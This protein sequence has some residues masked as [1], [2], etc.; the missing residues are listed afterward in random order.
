[1]LGGWM[2]GRREETESTASAPDDAAA[3]GNPF[4][5]WVALYALS[6]FC[7]LS[8]E[9]VWFRLLD[10]AL[11]SNA[12][13]F[14]TLLCLYLTGSAMGCLIGASFVARFK[15][16]LRAFLVCECVLLAYSG[17]VVIVLTS[18]SAHAPVMEWFVRYW[19]RGGGFKPLAKWDWTMILRLYVGLPLFLFGLPTVLMGLAFPILQRAVQRDVRGCGHRVGILQAANIVGCVA[20]SLLVGLLALGWLG[21]TGSLRLLMACGVIFA[22]LGLRAFRGLLFA[23]LVLV[24]VAVCLGLPS[25]RRLWTRLHGTDDPAA[26][27]EEDATSVAA[28]VPSGREWIVFVNG[29]SH[30]W[31]PFGGIHTQLGALP[32]V[33]HPAPADVAIVGLGSGDTSWAASCR[34]ETRAVSVFELS[35]PQPRLL[36]SLVQRE[37]IPKLRSFLLDPRVRIRTAD[38]RSALTHGDSPYDIV[39]ADA[40]WPEVAYSGNLYSVE[41]FAR[42]ARKLKPGGLMCTWAPTP[43]VYESFIAVFPYVVGPVEKHVLVGS[44]DPIPMTLEVWKE[45]LR[46]PDVVS[47]LGEEAAASVEAMLGRIVPLRRRGREARLKYANHDLYPRDEFLAP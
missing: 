30:S 45:R 23:A 18:L 44:P 25:Q 10:L 19:Q 16:P 47:Y 29:R 38:G 5:L 26:L 1:M 37:N 46:S 15:H 20:G 7:A 6:G 36:R 8:L 27:V 43:R 3:A 11:K 24:L 9:I 35:G 41:Y 33:M 22:L 12:F 13:T 28:I 32:A 40:L 34:P 4:A 31:L 2:K 14:G 42:C 17:L 21:S 39:E